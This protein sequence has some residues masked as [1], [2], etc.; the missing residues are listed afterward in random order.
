MLFNSIAYLVFLGLVW[1]L[2]SLLPLKWQNRLLLIASYVFYGSWDW[3]FLSLIWISTLSTYY[4]SHAIARTG[5]QKQRKRYVAFGA[6]LNL[7][8]LGVFKYFGFFHE[9]LQ[10]LAGALGIS[11]HGPAIHIILP[12]GISFYTFQA[13]SYLIDVYRK[14]YQPSQSLTNYALFISFFP[15]LVAGPIERPSHLLDQLEKPRRVT[16]EMLHEALYLLLWGFFKKVVVADTLALRADAVF[17]ADEFTSGMVIAGTVAFAFQIYADFSGY[18]DIARGSARLLG[19]RLNKNFLFPYFSKSPQE[20]WSRWHISLSTWLRD[21]LYIPLGGNRRGELKTYRNLIVTM[22][23]GGL[24]H[25]AAWNFVLWGGYHGAA[26]AIHRF[27]KSTYKSRSGT[28][29]SVVSGLIKLT[30]MT[31]VT[32]YGWLLFRA[33]SFQQIQDMTS[34]LFSSEPAALFLATFLKTCV[35][36]APLILVDFVCYRS[37]DEFAIVK[38]P[39][40]PLVLFYLALIYGIL[41]LGVTNV[42]QFIYFTF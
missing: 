15:Q 35:Y 23:L 10:D 20:F 39:L 6:M 19:I 21:Y 3:R 2:H 28:Q 38:W 24:W 17:S 7:G 30:L 37:N 11:L 29:H 25:G 42:Q 18:T 33:S 32:L 31:A 12:V 34:G 26:L 27:F 13:I 16:G 41:I 22:L 1:V 4:L 14:D 8:I 40:V 9:S 5:S 36:G